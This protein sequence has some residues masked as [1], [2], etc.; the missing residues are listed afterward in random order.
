M[1]EDYLREPYVWG[2]DI[3]SSNHSFSFKFEYR[4]VPVFLELSFESVLLCKLD[5][6]VL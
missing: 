1:C 6:V 4:N 3:E 2:T 5:P